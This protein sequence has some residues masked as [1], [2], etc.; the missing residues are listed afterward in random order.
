MFQLFTC[1]YLTF[2]FT[3]SSSNKINS[4]GIYVPENK[5]YEVRL[6]FLQVTTAFALEIAAAR[7][8]NTFKTNW[9]DWLM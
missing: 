2:L 9:R 8:V 3:L 1:L 6:R 7:L 5:P 4:S